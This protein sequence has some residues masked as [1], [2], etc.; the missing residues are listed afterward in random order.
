MRIGGRLSSG[1]WTTRPCTET[2]P[3]IQGLPVWEH[4]RHL[5]APIRMPLP[6]RAIDPSSPSIPTRP[7]STPP[8]RSAPM[9]H[10]GEGPSYNVKRRS[11]AEGNG[12]PRNPLHRTA[13]RGPA[14][15]ARGARSRCGP[16]PTR[17]ERGA[18][19]ED[20]PTSCQP[21][22]VH[23]VLGRERGKGA[24]NHAGSEP[25]RKNDSSSVG[26]G[27]SRYQDGSSGRTAS[28]VWMAAG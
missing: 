24:R 22:P 10:L 20:R 9:A 17:P 1:A 3:P 14:T 25:V 6:R 4:R 21:N 13:G 12:S 8:T 5:D 23:P 28:E 18:E 19:A 26:G 16:L 7:P 2:S 15:S 11:P 27:V